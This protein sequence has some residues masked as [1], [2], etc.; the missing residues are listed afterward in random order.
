MLLPT[1]A[2]RALR[3]ADFDTLVQALDH[4]ATGPTGL[5]LHSLRGELVEA[6]SYQRL[7][8]EALALAPRL[9]AAGLEAG[10]R[11][12]L[13]DHPRDRRRQ[14]LRLRADAVEGLA[15][16]DQALELGVRVVDLD[17]RDRAAGAQL[18]VA[19]DPAR[20]DGDLLVELALALAPL[21]A[22]LPSGAAAVLQLKPI[23]GITLAQGRATP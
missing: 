6:L 14:S 17:L 9:L 10:D 16:V 7:R 13:G 23:Q 22:V 20:D 2:D 8:T 21:P 5:N 4:A 11:V 12:G 19:L 18:A 3:L 15:A 1:A